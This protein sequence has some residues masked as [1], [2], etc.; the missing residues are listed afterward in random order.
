MSGSHPG[1]PVL[2]MRGGTSKGA[3]FLARDLPFLARDL[4]F[5]ARDPPAS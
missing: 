3:Y 2:L 1:I 5:L 4:P